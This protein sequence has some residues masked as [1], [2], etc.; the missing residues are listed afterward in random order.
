LLQGDFPIQAA[1]ER[2][3]VAEDE[4]LVEQLRDHLRLRSIIRAVRVES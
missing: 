4:I 2:L 3:H 1:R